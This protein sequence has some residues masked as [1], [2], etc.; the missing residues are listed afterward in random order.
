[1]ISEGK[2]QRATVVDEPQSLMVKQNGATACS[3]G[4]S[5]EMASRNGFRCGARNPGHRQVPT[6]L[7]ALIDMIRTSR[8][9][10]KAKRV[11]ENPFAE[12]TERDR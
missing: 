7:R 3:R 8:E 4:P 12:M 11:I 2:R 9:P 10:A 1:V 6:A 5:S